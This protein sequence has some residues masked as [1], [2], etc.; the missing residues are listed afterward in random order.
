M[1]RFLT[2][3][4]S[5]GRGLVTIVEGLPAG[6]SL[7]IEE[8]AAELARRRMG[9]GRGRRMNIEKDRLTVLAGVR[10]GAT[11]G[12]PVAVLIENTEWERWEPTLSPEPRQPVD[13]TTT[14]R[15]GHADLAGM[16]RHDTHDV[17]D[18]LERASARETAARTIAGYAAR[19]LL[20]TIGIEVLSH[21]VSIGDITAPPVTPVPSDAQQ[22]DASPVRVL[23]PAS[24]KAM[25]AA[26]DEARAERDTLG[27]IF[28]VLAHNVPPG[29]GTYAHWDRRLDGL[30]A[31]AM[32]SIPAIKG[33]ELGDGFTQARSKGS[34]SHDEIE[35]GYGRTT[36]R[37]GGVEGGMSNG[38]TIR[39]RGAMKPLP[40]LMRALR[41]VDVST[42]EPAGA[43]RE[44]SDVCA[45]PPAAVVGEQM[46]CFVLARETL[47]MLGGA[48]VSDY[49]AGAAAYRARIAGF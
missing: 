43:L 30:L 17:R 48:T 40:T 49:Q 21:V 16:M 1:L 6:L 24:E 22:L 38:E 37:A 8:I 10:Y 32:M 42:G 3:G 9:H 18:V 11:T 47:A 2:A 23:D 28:E 5:H 45:V 7:S 20:R 39:V 15:P 41:S 12:A 33:V 35:V 29:V 13:A 19:C 44:R 27:G 36:N 26:I 14:P 4:E 34:G 46:V 31:Q 25:T